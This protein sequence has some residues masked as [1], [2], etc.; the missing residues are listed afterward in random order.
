MAPCVGTNGKGATYMAVVALTVARIAMHRRLN[1]GRLRPDT[2]HEGD[3][4]G[5]PGDELRGDQPHSAWVRM[6][7]TIQWPEERLRSNK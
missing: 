3:N 6:C 2:V 5:G 4:V 1:R 7:V